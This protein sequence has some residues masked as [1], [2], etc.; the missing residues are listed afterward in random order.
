LKSKTTNQNPTSTTLDFT[1]LDLQLNYYLNQK[2]QQLT[3]FTSKEEDISLNF[4]LNRFT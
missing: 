2:T 4:L 3:Q 1:N